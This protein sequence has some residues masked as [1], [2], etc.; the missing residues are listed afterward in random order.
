MSPISLSTLVPNV[1][2]SSIGFAFH[3]YAA[4]WPA[5]DGRLGAY[6]RSQIAQKGLIAM[7]AMWDNGFRQIT[8]SKTP[9]ITPDDLKGFKIRVPPSPLWQLM[10]TAFGAA[11]ATIH[12]AETYT[13]LSTG[14]VDGQENPLAIIST[15]KIYEVQN[16]CAMTNH[17]WDGF[18]LLGNKRAWNA[19]PEDLQQI[20]ARNFNMSAAQQRADSQK[21]NQTLR[22][23]LASKGMAFTDPDPKAF[24]EVLNQAGFYAECKRQYGEEAWTLLEEAVG[25]DLG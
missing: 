7:D 24:R 9:I 14:I 8:T 6:A 1:A 20:C 12:W 19:L 5:I 16:H 17:V 21:L 4:V 18:W 11:P 2:I 22:D 23:E 15:A 13:A 10:F 3:D 25:A